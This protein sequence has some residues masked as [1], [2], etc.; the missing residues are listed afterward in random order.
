MVPPF[1]HPVER[2]AD[3]VFVNGF[4]LTFN[5]A[6]EVAEELAVRDGEIVRVGGTGSCA[7]VT[8]PHTDVVD[9][10]GGTL[11]PGLNDSHLHALSFGLGQPPLTLDVGYPNVNSI[12]D[13]KRLVAER[14]TSL[15]PGEWV[16]GTGWDPGYLSECV[17][18]SGRIPTATDLDEVAPHNPVYLHD[19]SYHSAWVNS[20][21]LELAGIDRNYV[22]PEGSTVST[23][24]GGNPSGILTEG[25]RYPVREL[26][27]NWTHEQRVFAVKNAITTLNSLGITSYTEPGIGSGD[28]G[29][30]MG[31]GGMEVYSELLASGELTARV[32]ILHFP[33]KM[34]G[35]FDEFERNLRAVADPVTANAPFADERHVRV[36]GVKIMGDGIP[37]N[38]TSWMHEPYVGGGCGGLTVAGD[39][40]HER[41]E[42]LRKMIALTHQLGLQAGVHI[43]GDRG[44]DVVVDA[45]VE[46]MREH[47]RDDQRH[48]VIHGDFITPETLKRCAAHG[49]GVNM[50]PTIKWTIADLEVDFVGAERAAY[51]WPF[52][53]ALDA[54]ARVSSGSDAPITFPDWRQGVETM[55]T[56][57]AKASGEVSG[58]EQRIS[59]MEAL[60]TYTATPAWQDFDESWKGSLEVGKVADLCVLRENILKQPHD[61]L[62][63]VTVAAT[64]LDGKLVYSAG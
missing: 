5:E 52:R 12:A 50:N 27:P 29:G 42:V 16:L 23:D 46:A 35:G 6:D 3:L 62:S 63:Q 24:S 38:K 22:V 10:A 33:V 32:R 9:L 2:P 54:G 45:F 1:E 64:Y 48:Y 43:T 47:P 57:R 25:A 40:E 58:P 11:L 61:Q 19:F 56:R 18:E 13:V 55:V 51:E 30:G 28:E 26:L 7:S 21:A 44:I 49:I 41:E 31:E 39:D 4:V 8:G 60:R 37:P 34:S 15:A 59:V 53:T 17:N 14:V 36:I 20:L